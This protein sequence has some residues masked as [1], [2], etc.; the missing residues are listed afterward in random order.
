[1]SDQKLFEAAFPYAD[2]VLALPVEDIDQAANWY[3]EKFDMKEIQRRA[4]PLPTVILER[5]G[6]EIGFHC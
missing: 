5:D 3:G 4:S 2:D 6:V 1:M